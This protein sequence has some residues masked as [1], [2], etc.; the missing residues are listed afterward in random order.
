MSEAL[1]AE[2]L[3][4][5]MPFAATLGVRFDRL[6]ATEVSAEL[7]WSPALC[8]VGQ[9]MHGGALVSLADSVGGVCAFLNLPAG[10]VTTTIEVKC[11]F[12]LAVRRGVVRAVARPMHVG[13]SVIVVATDLHQLSGGDAPA[14]SG[15]TRVAHAVQ[16]QL[17]LR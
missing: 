15:A 7:D 11:N 5:L 10:A 9:V 4:E 8:T 2:R 17:V 1:T 12:F 16:S 3:R 14:G 6:D 13:R